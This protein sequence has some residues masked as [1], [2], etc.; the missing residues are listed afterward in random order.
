MQTGSLA[1]VGQTH[2]DRFVTEVTSRHAEDSLT[3]LWAIWMMRVI[4][5]NRVAPILLKGMQRTTGNHPEETRTAAINAIA[6]HGH[7]SG[8]RNLG[9]FRLLTS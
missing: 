3:V 4:P 5:P 2:L 1:R 7:P 6:V 8:G 9:R